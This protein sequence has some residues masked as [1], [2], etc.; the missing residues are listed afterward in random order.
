MNKYTEL[1]KKIADAQIKV[2]SAERRHSAVNVARDGL[3][4]ILLNNIET[5]L[6][7]LS[8]YSK[9]TEERDALQIALDDADAELDK[10]KKTSP[11][12]KKGDVVDGKKE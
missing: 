2:V 9:V 6:E 11:K 7:C 5:I 10:I 3:K 12:P 4:N 1:H 8:N